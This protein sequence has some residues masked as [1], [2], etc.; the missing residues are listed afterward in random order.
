[1]E[2]IKGLNTLQVSWH[3]TSNWSHSGC[4]FSI[5][6][7]LWR[8]QRKLF[9]HFLSFI[10]R[11]SLTL[12]YFL[13][14]PFDVEMFPLL[15]FTFI[16]KKGTF[17]RC[18]MKA[19]EYISVSTAS[20]TTFVVN[21]VFQLFEGDFSFIKSSKPD[22]ILFTFLKFRTFNSLSF[23]FFDQIPNHSRR[24][25]FIGKPEIP[26]WRMLLP[27]FLHSLFWLFWLM[28]FQE[29][30]FIFDRVITHSFQNLVLL[31]LCVYHQS[32]LVA[33]GRL[34]RCHLFWF[35]PALPAENTVKGIFLELEDDNR[36][37]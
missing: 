10:H 16:L 21:V 7:W 13:D 8:R 2:E 33:T 18:K 31:S 17:R 29:N 23:H 11:F 27:V 19:F 14:Q 25:L 12:C 26:N 5:N 37:Y 20:T 15:R 6:L 32:C 3:F 22:M 9:H 24:L 35:L 1:M 34:I 28:M 36:R 30:A 4:V